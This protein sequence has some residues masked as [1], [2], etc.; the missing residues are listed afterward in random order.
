MYSKIKVKVK[1][2]IILIFGFIVLVAYQNCSGGK[3]G[4]VGGDSEDFSSE[5]TV[6][7]NKALTIL[8]TKCS[9]C[10]DSSIKAG[11]VDVLNLDEMLALGVVVPNEPLLSLLFTEVQSGQ[12]PPN[13]ALSVAEIQT[14]SDWI[15]L[16]F[17]TAP[18]IGTLPPGTAIPLGPTFASINA[19]I[20]SK[21][22]LGCHNVGNPAGGVSYSTYASTM[23]TVQRTLPL[24]STMYTSVATRMTMP[25]SGGALNAAETK[26]IFDWITA[27]AA[28]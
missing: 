8:A 22:C 1:L 11:G 19:N 7:S 23:N 3:K 10:H 6:V 9:S 4:D 17:A 13:K 28:Q 20:L 16:G 18:V 26:A 14:I 2:I 21:R 24:Q 25:K 5:Q 27:G 15:Q 12:M